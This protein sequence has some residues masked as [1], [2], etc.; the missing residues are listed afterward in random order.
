MFFDDVSSFICVLFLV[1]F[2]HCFSFPYFFPFSLFSFLLSYFIEELLVL[3]SS[4][5]V[6]VLRPPFR[7]FITSLL[8]A[9]VSFWCFFY[10]SLTSHIRMRD[11][12]SVVSLDFLFDILSRLPS[13]LYTRRSLHTCLFTCLFF[14][15]RTPMSLR[16]PTLIFSP[17]L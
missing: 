16:F 4:V 1:L 7:F 17:C 3:T 2:L 10:F 9:F 11:R 15:L 6:Y 5:Y 13:C 8:S 14:L 12:S